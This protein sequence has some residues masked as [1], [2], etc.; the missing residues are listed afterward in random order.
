MGCT[1]TIFVALAIREDKPALG[2]GINGGWLLAVVATQAICV[3]GCAIRPAP[4]MPRDHELFF[5]MSFWLCGGMLYI[6]MIALIF[7]R[8]MFFRFDPA[9]L[10]PPY[11]INMGAVAISTLAGTMLAAAAPESSLIAALLPFVKGLTMM[12]WS[13]ATWWIPM[14]VILGIWRHSVKKIPIGYHPLY[15]GLVFPLG[16]YSLCTWRLSMMLQTPMLAAVA[17]V[18]VVFA[19]VAWWLTFLGVAQKIVF[20]LLLAVRSIQG[21]AAQHARPVVKLAGSKVP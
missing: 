1:Y 4:F 7:Y 2:E 9:D 16:M 20:A 18:F 17:K 11:W 5:L 15:W 3:L 6:W 19:L 14:L 21:A 10:M 8:Y 13:T 12:F